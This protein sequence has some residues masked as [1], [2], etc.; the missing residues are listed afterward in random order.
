MAILTIFFNYK[1]IQGGFFDVVQIIATTATLLF[2]N[3]IESFARSIH[4]K[5]ER[6]YSSLQLIA[7]NLALN[8]LKIMIQWRFSPELETIVSI[9]RS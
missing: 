9:S 7:E 5:L 6:L 2:S 3:G 1:F 8:M 4:L